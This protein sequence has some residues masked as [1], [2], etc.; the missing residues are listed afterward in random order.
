MRV[1]WIEARP[2][3]EAFWKKGLFAHQRTV[4]PMR[5]QE[6]LTQLVEHFRLSDV[7]REMT[8]KRSYA[9]P[10]ARPYT[11]HQDPSPTN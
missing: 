8:A 5:D 10:A 11:N 2:K 9:A 6:T 1:E 3:E 4:L 7:G